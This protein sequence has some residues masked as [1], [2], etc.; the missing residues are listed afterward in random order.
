M[1][2]LTLQFYRFSIG[3]KPALSGDRL[4]QQLAEWRATCDMS[5]ENS[6]H[7]VMPRR[8]F[9]P[10]GA[11][12]QVCRCASE[13]VQVCRYTGVQVGKCAGVKVQV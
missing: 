3:R 10:A 13:Q 5:S 12:V 4:W 9:S 6:L 7:W 1:E 11:G 2:I 8:L